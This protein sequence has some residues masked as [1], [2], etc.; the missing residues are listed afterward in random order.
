M[1]IVGAEYIL[2]LLPKGTHEYKKLI[3]PSELNAFAEQAHL[4]LKD[5][6]GV[7]YNP[8]SGLSSLSKNVDVNYMMCYRYEPTN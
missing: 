5:L 6:I 8:W 7:H 3:K 4:Q 2:N 1:A